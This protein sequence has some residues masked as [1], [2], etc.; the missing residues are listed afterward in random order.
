MTNRLYIY[1]KN[2]THDLEQVFEKL[3][4][5]YTIEYHNHSIMIVKMMDD[6]LEKDIDYRMFQASIMSDFNVDTSLV[7][8]DKKVFQFISEAMIINH[9]QYLK[10]QAYNI[11]KL[12]LSMIYNNINKEALKKN[13]LNLLGQDYIDTAL[14]IA[15]NNMN[16]SVSAKK[17]YIHR[18]TLNYRIEKIY[19]KT[20]I[21]IKTFE[22]LTVFTSLYAF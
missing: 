3:Y 2:L 16:F 4:K 6:I 11:T 10:S 18:N 13:I 9:L 17:L 14:I 19:E 21:D 15:K 12:I 1:Q 8:V 7:Y 5:D 20:D 22:G